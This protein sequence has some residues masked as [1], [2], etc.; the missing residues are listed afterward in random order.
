MAEVIAEKSEEAKKPELSPEEKAKD[1][2]ASE[3][4]K[5]MEADEKPGDEKKDEPESSE[6]KEETGESEPESDAEAERGSQPEKATRKKGKSGFKKRQSRLVN[7]RNEA[8]A[9]KDEV[10]QQL[11]DEREEKKLLRM[12]IQQLE[13]APNPV[14]EPNPDS[15]DGGDLDPDYTKA[16]KDFD[17]AQLQKLVRETVAETNQQGNQTLAK[18]NHAKDL[19]QKQEKHWER[20]DELGASDY[21]EAEEEV[22]KVMGGNMVNGIIHD[23]PGDSHKVIYYLGKNPD[24]AE[25]IAEMLADNS[26]LAKGVAQIG[27]IIERQST[28]DPLTPITPD[29]DEETEGSAPSAH[30]ALQ[31]KLDKLREQATKSG[32]GGM[33]K[34]LAFKKKARERGITLR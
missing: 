30:E 8:L 22:V 10:S 17:Q 24:E 18:E 15:F 1:V 32:S 2:A 20:A 31:Q 21:D 34:I 26:T 23:F 6:E 29:P 12:R 13:G 14:T 27:R 25:D 16:K 5:E 33:K 9:E 7:Q 11:Y 3:L 19:K 4:L 28:N